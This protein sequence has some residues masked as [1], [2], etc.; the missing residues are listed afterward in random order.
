MEVYLS[1]SRRSLTCGSM[2]CMV[3][4]QLGLEW[5]GKAIQRY[6]DIAFIGYFT[7]CC[8]KKGHDGDQMV[9]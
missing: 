9:K 1:T 3:W 2:S 5:Q 6:M 8:L 4:F 7:L